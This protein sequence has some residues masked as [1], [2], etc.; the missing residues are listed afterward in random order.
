MTAQLLADILGVSVR[1]IYRDVDA[2]S[3][4]HVPISMDFGPGGGYFLPESY[5]MDPTA[6]TPREA[7]ALALGAAV[8]AGS[9]LLDAEGLQR[10]LIKLEALLPES[11]REEIRA[12][13]ERVVLDETAWHRKPDR[14]EYLEPI[15][16]ALWSRRRIEIL[17]RRIDRPASEW[18]RV[19]P[20]GLVCKAGVWYLVAY[21]LL[22]RDYRTFRLNRVTELVVLDEPVDDHPKFDLKDYWEVSR[23]RFEEASIRLRLVLRVSPHVAYGLSSDHETIRREADGQ[24]IVTIGMDNSD[25]ALRHA[26]A[27]GPEAEVLEPAEVR[28]AVAQASRDIA[29]IYSPRVEA[30]PGNGRPKAIGAA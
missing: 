10:A 11:V 18:R 29:A 17:Y 1:T 4:A 7:I 14:I 15:R 9:P 25:H 13:S 8:A 3:L 28:R 19:E 16:A 20:L 24:V 30:L 6:F 12:A 22:R 23:R 27:L 26:L 5:R 21:C 2:L